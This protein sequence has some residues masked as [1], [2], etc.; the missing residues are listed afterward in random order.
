MSGTIDRDAVLAR[1]DFET[2]YANELGASIVRKGGANWLC[3]S[4]F[5]EDRNPSFSVNVHTGVFN[6]F[7]DESKR[8]DV[9]AFIMLRNGVTFP[10]AVE[11]V[12]RYAGAV[13]LREP[14]RPA[15][16]PEQRAPEV[17]GDSS[18]FTW[19]EYGPMK[20]VRQC[21]QVAD[22]SRIDMFG[23]ESVDF[24]VSAFLHTEAIK[25][26]GDNYAAAVRAPGVW[27]DIDAVDAENLPDAQLDAI[28][29][30]ERLVDHCGIDMDA[31]R[32][33]FSGRRGFGM[34]LV[35]PGFSAT[36][37][38]TDTPTLMQDMA[39]ALAGPVKIDDC[40]YKARQY[41]RCPNTR[42]GKTSLYRIPIL[43]R[44]LYG[45]VANIQ[46]RARTQRSMAQAIKETVSL[47]GRVA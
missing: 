1:V 5:R 12:N 9:F 4:P 25:T 35:S 24:C 16:K 30:F 15:P 36:T 46:R 39:H 32:I 17:P 11:Y 33:W 28:R 22:Y 29:L 41:I 3:R 31:L 14:A 45:D 34:H 37:G 43:A 10:Q 21:K 13:A 7:A 6:D 26:A 18:L 2:F 42:H 27:F 38:T 20:G 23:R 40:I 8:G 44:E 47:I 19:I